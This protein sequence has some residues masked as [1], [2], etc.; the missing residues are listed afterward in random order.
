MFLLDRKYHEPTSSYQ[1]VRYNDATREEE[2]SPFTSIPA[3]FWWFFVT[4]TTV[5]YGDTVPVTAPGK[6]V[7]I[8]AML[9]GVLVIAF[10]V[11]VFSDLW[12]KE[13][14]KTG[15]LAAIE[16]SSDSDGGGDTEEE[17]PAQAK[18][19]SAFD[20]SHRLVHPEHRHPYHY[21]EPQQQPQPSAGS[22]NSGGASG[23]TAA[24][25]AA[26][27]AATAQSSWHNADPSSSSSDRDYVRV[28]KDDL[29]ELLAGVKAME[30]ESRR[31][32]SILRKYRHYGTS[33]ISPG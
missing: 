21:W 30:E 20:L 13:L 29:A 12:S 2:I 15:A 23:A 5:G 6:W 16:E 31:V 17:G 27:G 33:K 11:S 8:A 26:G 14:R 1:F 19:P 10:P 28:H 25:A 4:A 24:A 3:C 22:Q 9:T 18:P 32:R 7:G